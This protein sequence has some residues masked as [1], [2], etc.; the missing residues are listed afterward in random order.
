MA[1]EQGTDAKRADARSDIYSLGATWYHMITGRV[2]FDGAT[3]LEIW[4]KHLKEPVRPVTAVQPGVPRGV[5]LTIEQMMAKDPDHRIQT[6]RQVCEMIRERCLG[7]RDIARELGLER[8]KAPESLWD[9]KIVVGGRLEKRRFALS[10]VR[11]RIRKGQVTRDTPTR[12]AGSRDEYQPAAAFRE[13]AREFPRDYAVRTVTDIPKEGADARAQLHTMVEHF[14]DMQ[15][16]HRRKRMLR[17]WTPYLVQ[18]A[19]LLA[20]AALVWKFWPNI[21]D[22]VTGLVQRASN[23]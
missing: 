17:R 12:R 1:P 6:A 2:P 11:T 19:V 14:D 23:P 7:E 8:K 22:L 9:M 15:R 21:R 5:S 16:A 18:L 10:E 20:L 3:P 4:Q 13:L